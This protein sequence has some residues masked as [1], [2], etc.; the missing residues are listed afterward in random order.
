M[1]LVN[2]KIKNQA[3][4]WDHVLS[5]R[6]LITTGSDG[7]ENVIGILNGK[8]FNFTT[9]SEAKLNLD[10]SLK[11]E[12]KMKEDKVKKFLYIYIESGVDKYGFFTDD[13][14]EKFR[15]SDAK[16]I[17]SYDKHSEAWNEV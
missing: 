5:G 7:I 15:T 3:D 12:I 6:V 9:G 11:Y 1:E 14:F 4:R 10:D 2:R 13:E 17:S 8:L 16:N